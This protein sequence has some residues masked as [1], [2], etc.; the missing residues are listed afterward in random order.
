MMKDCPLLVTLDQ[1]DDQDDENISEMTHNLRF[2]SPITRMI[3]W[4]LLKMIATTDNKK[5]VYKVKY[6][7]AKAINA[8]LQKSTTTAL[9]KA[10]TATQ[11]LPEGQMKVVTRSSTPVTIPKAIGPPQPLNTF[12]GQPKATKAAK[13]VKK[14]T[15]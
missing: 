11:T 7:Q 6:Q 4:N 15:L 14:R 1:P 2:K 9:T 12:Q 10:M 13:I 8:S 3:M 5:K